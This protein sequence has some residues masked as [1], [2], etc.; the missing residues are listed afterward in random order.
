MFSLAMTLAPGSSSGQSLAAHG[1]RRLLGDVVRRRGLPF[2]HLLP[3]RGE[4]GREVGVGMVEHREGI[5]G[6]HGLEA[7]HGRRDLRVD[8]STPARSSSR[9]RFWR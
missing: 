7:L 4:V 9:F 8:R 5:R 3:L 1:S 2:C 6:G